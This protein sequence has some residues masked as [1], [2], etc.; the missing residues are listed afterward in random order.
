MR[1]AYITGSAGLMLDAQSVINI[2]YQT[3]YRCID[4]RS[5]KTQNI[6]FC[7][8]FDLETFESS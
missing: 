8:Y 5:Q 3:Q 7:F 6:D 4:N 2:I 1:Q